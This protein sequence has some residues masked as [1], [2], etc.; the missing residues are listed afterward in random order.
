MANEIIKKNLEKLI[1]HNNGDMEYKSML[2]SES[3]GGNAFF[4]GRIAL[5][6]CKF[7]L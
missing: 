6:W 5:S 2:E 4:L 3:M 1:G 7:F